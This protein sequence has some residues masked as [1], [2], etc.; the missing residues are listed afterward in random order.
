MEP[1]RSKESLAWSKKAESGSVTGEKLYTKEKWSMKDCPLPLR[2][3]LAMG[4]EGLLERHINKS[5][6][7]TAKNPTGILEEYLPLGN[8]VQ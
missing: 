2:K 3:N 1:A 8:D 5:S 7:S 4:N 6:T